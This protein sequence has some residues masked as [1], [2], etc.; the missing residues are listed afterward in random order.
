MAQFDVVLMPE[1]ERLTPALGLEAK[2]AKLVVETVFGKRHTIAP[3]RL[4]HRESVDA[5]TKG[6]AA[7]QL[8]EMVERAERLAAE[9]DVELLW[10]SVADREDPATLRT[11]A[12]AWFGDRA[13][14]VELKATDLAIVGSDAYFERVRQRYRPLTRA[15][16][17]AALERARRAAERERVLDRMT[18]SVKARLDAPDAA[19][20][21]AWSDAV[22][23]LASFTIN[24]SG[25]GERIVER[26]GAHAQGPSRRHAAVDLLVAT[27]AIARPTDLLVHRHRLNR[28]FGPQH[29]AAVADVVEAVTGALPDRPAAPTPAFTIDDVDTRDYDDAISVDVTPDGIRLGV[30]I[31][32]PAPFVPRG[33]LLDETAYSRGTTVYLPDRKYPMFPAALSEDALSL[34]AGVER[35]VLSFY[36]AFSDEQSEPPEPTI[37]RER[38]TIADNL[39]YADVDALLAGDGD[40]D[41]PHAAAVRIADRIARARRAARDERGAVALNQPELRISVD[42]DGSVR[43]RRIDADTAARALVAEAMILVNHAGAAW[44]A[45]REVPAIYRGQVPPAEPVHPPVPYDPVAFRREVRKMQKARLATAP[46]P[47]AGLG[48]EC[49]TQL[50][51]PLRRYGDLVIH[52][53]LAAA[54]AGAPLPF[55]DADDLLAVVVTSDMNYQTAVGAERRA[56]RAWALRALETRLGEPEAAIVVDVAP[57]REATVELVDTGV[58]GRIGGRETDALA[59]GDHVTVRVRA[60]DVIDEQPELELVE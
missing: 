19:A 50:S 26:L 37:V 39:S 28:A 33:S 2:G 44:L 12:G 42:D 43:A 24:G 16:R 53:Q 40:D 17:S 4:A 46:A 8:R 45:T 27:R 47:H 13:G 9:V 10:E 30:H 57:G 32:D 56:K 25:P 60:I 23:A 35:P 34:R 20:D 22:D 31:A 5:A 54:L 51:S 55:D 3:D 7:A 18:A 48:L 29:E 58:V 14:L 59:V 1:G 38:I 41:A 52:R 21:D 15:Q 11:L 36:F 49:Y 6:D